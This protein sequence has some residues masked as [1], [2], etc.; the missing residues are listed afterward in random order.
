MVLAGVGIMFTGWLWLDPVISLVIV[1]VIFLSTWGLVRDSFRL[2]LD[3]VP[4]HVDLPEV[5][6]WLR[7]YEGVEDVHDLHIW[8]VST[9]DT[10]LTAHL[11]MPAGNPPG[12][13]QRVSED[14]HRQFG[15]G[16]T[17]LQVEAAEDCQLNSGHC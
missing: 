13:L 6:A 9:T 5:D 15:I 8:P 7:G 1:A 2:S 14:L 12:L 17:T 10:C 11:V 16:H 4:P 3:Q